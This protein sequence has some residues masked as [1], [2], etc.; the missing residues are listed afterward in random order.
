M[1]W[2]ERYLD[3]AD[4]TEAR[5]RKGYIQEKMVMWSFNRDEA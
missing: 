4:Y 1:G 3:L 2:L 5:D